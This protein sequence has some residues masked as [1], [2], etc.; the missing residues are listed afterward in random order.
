MN[1]SEKNLNM[2]YRHLH[3]MHEQ[4]GKQMKGKWFELCL[5]EFKEY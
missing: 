1:I 4:A 2:Y 3:H 5:N